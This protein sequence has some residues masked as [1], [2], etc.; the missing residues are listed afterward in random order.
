MVYQ[1][2]SD[3]VAHRLQRQHESLQ[4]QQPRREGAPHC[5]HHP[6]TSLDFPALSQQ[7]QGSRLG[8]TASRQNEKKTYANTV[9]S[10]MLTAI[11]RDFPCA[12]I[13]R[14]DRIFPGLILDRTSSARPAQFGSTAS[15]L[16][17]ERCANG[18]RSVLNKEVVSETSSDQL[19]HAV[20]PARNVIEDASL[21]RTPHF[22]KPTESFVKR[23][24]GTLRKIPVKVDLSK[25]PVISTARMDSR[26]TE[27][28]NTMMKRPG[29]SHQKRKSLPGDWLNVDNVEQIVGTGEVTF[30][31]GNTARPGKKSSG[32]AVSKAQ[33]NA[34]FASKKK[35]AHPRLPT[36]TT[37]YMATTNAA[38][39]RN[40]ASLIKEKPEA[41]TVGVKTAVT[42]GNVG[43]VA[44]QTPTSPQVCGTLSPLKPRSTTMSSGTSSVDFILDASS[45]TAKFPSHSRDR[46]HLSSVLNDGSPTLR[47]N[48]N[49]RSPLAMSSARCT[50]ARSPSKLPRPSARGEPS[51]QR[52]RICE[53]AARLA[54][55]ETPAMAA[56]VQSKTTT[57]RR[58]S[59]APLLEP[60]VARLDAKG[61]LN[62]ITSNNAVVESYLQGVSRSVADDHP[63]DVPQS[64]S[65]TRSSHNSNVQEPGRQDPSITTP[66]ECT[67]KPHMKELIGARQ[68]DTS[69]PRPNWYWP[70]N[71]PTGAV[72]R[73]DSAFAAGTCSSAASTIA[74][75]VYSNAGK[76]H[77]KQGSSL[78]ATANEFRPSFA[79][80]SDAHKAGAL[81]FA[82]FVPEDEWSQMNYEQQRTIHAMRFLYKTGAWLPESSAIQPRL[83]TSSHSAY[84]VS[85][86][87]SMQVKVN[88]SPA[89]TARFVDE[90][91]SPCIVT[92]DET[93]KPDLGPSKQSVQALRSIGSRLTFGRAPPP[94]FPRMSDPF[95]PTIS[96]TSTGTSPA[97]TPSSLRG[98][99]I[100]SANSRVPYGWTGGDGKEIKFIGY[101]PYAE[102]DPNSTV[103]FDFQGRTASLN[104]MVPNGF[105]V[106]E[107][108]YPG[109]LVAPRSQRQW[110][111]KC[112]YTKVPCRDVEIV[113]AVEHLPTAAP[114]GGELVAYCHDC[115]GN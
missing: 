111:E 58:V 10:N 101:G 13:K 26:M 103:N 74:E 22:A 23:A 75:A 99:H 40:L 109:N 100:D 33:S 108:G 41:N 19:R 78:R 34:E 69:N 2:N 115:V 95:T 24:G 66:G 37:S 39:Y 43:Q 49:H 44:H 85:A 60:I 84:G 106:K 93:S 50:D 112:G 32:Q 73:R 38:M 65:A 1:L 53:D 81:D 29:Q 56:K 36:K 35:Q 62:K 18:E 52:L 80:S 94:A 25:H 67:E 97:K 68:D 76:T 27:T 31:I 91:G 83:D 82:R 30:D 12:S 4:D 54:R 17:T 70:N 113:H 59:N 57:K 55:S 7:Q 98:W 14:A 61:L 114:S 86:C 71:K 87:N 20:E 107:N 64:H 21:Q 16:T 46:S 47:Q 72:K 3:S 96:P 6:P 42:P 51:P 8:A 104:A 15:N 5:V 48:R 105:E 88:A 92:G 110:A 63:A 89:V 102:R 77:A 79:A 11:D 45:Q 28:D 90:N 9:A